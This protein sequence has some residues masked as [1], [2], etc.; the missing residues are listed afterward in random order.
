MQVKVDTTTHM[1]ILAASSC[2]EC[3]NNANAERLDMRESV[4]AGTGYIRDGA[5]LMRYDN[6]TMQGLDAE[7]RVCVGLTCMND[8]PIFVV[9]E[10][11]DWTTQVMQRPINGVFG[12]ARPHK[13]ALLDKY[14]GNDYVL[15]HSSL[16]T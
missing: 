7:D 9:D 10:E 15:E 6:S 16:W 1:V 4:D 12:L 3:Y 14:V 8:Q 5:A 2:E 13:V 11:L